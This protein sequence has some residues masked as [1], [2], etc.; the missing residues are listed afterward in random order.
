MLCIW[1]KFNYLHYRTICG[2]SKR[3]HTL[4]KEKT[5]LLISLQTLKTIGRKIKCG[6]NRKKLSQEEKSQNDKETSTLDIYS[7]RSFSVVVCVHQ[8]CVGC[9]IM[10][11]VSLVFMLNVERLSPWWFTIRFTIICNKSS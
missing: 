3:R 8:I 7:E 5:R 4:S 11:D 10:F 6:Q 2:G 1:I 9:V